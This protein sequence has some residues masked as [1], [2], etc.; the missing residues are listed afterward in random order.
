MTTTPHTGDSTTSLLG[1]VV[2]DMRDLMAA[3]AERAKIEAKGELGNLKRTIQ[4]TGIAVA[5]IVVSA[6][7]LG[8]ALALGLVA[9]GV[10]AWAGF[11]LVA[12]VAGIGGYIAIKRRP[13]GEDSDLVPEKSIS[14]MRQD[15]ERLA[16]AVRG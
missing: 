15:A 2:S 11:G 6:V 4:V 12:I 14:A 16:E 9:L 10:P 7:M 1:G 8:C 13:A 3:H 5:S